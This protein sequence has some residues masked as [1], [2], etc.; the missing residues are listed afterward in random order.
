MSAMQRADFR[1][2]LQQGLYATFG[3]NYEDW[4]TEW[5]EIFESDKSTK[6]YEEEVMLVGL[7]IAEDTG[8]GQAVGYD[9]GGEAWVSRYKHKK[10]TKA[11]SVTEEAVDDN[12]YHNVASLY[13]K[14][15]ARAIRTREEVDGAGVLNNG[16]SASH[17]GGDGAPLFSNLH[18][19]SGPSG[20]YGVNTFATQADLSDDSLQDMV[21]MISRA[22]DDRGVPIMLRPQKLVV[23]VENNFT[24]QRI[25][26]SDLRSGT[27][28]N[29]QNALKAQ[30]SIPKGHCVNHYITDPDMWV[31][32]TDADQ[33]L[34]HFD[35]K[36]VKKSSEY[37][38]DTGNL[39]VKFTRRFSFGWTNWR[40]GYGSS[41][42][43]I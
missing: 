6:A 26:H 39:R 38:F 17:L 21:N 25:L 30:R 42:S 20:G 36:G 33:G 23:A 18:P 8:E 29:D 22:T 32:L 5:T 2:E 28:N 31:V 41:G 35:R 9:S 19:L 34:R 3:L 1:R 11:F 10:V 4:T 37:D 24:A 13:S 40:G 15:A 14:S 7:G 12:Q 16:F 43:A 27:A